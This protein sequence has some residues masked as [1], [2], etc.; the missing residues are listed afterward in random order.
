MSVPVSVTPAAAQSAEDSEVE[1]LPLA[2]LL[3]SDGYAERAE[4]V[5]LGVDL[6]EKDLDLARYYTLMGLVHSQLGRYAQAAAAWEEALSKEGVDP[7]VRLQIAQ[8]YLQNNEPEK[9][10]QTLTEVEPELDALKATW[11]VRVRAQWVSAD[12]EGAWISLARAEE[13]FPEDLEFSR[14]RV[15]LLVDMGLYH[16]ALEQGRQVLAKGGAAEDWLSLGEAL[17]GAGE[18]GDAV[19]LLEEGRLRYPLNVSLSTALARVYL[20]SGRPLAAGEVLAIAG[21]QD[22]ELLLTAAECFRQ[23]GELDRAL[24]L[25][26]RVADPQEK[27]KQRLGLYI[28]QQDW[29]R[30]VALGGRLERLSL[31]EDDAVAYALAYAWFRMGDTDR[32]TSFLTD[33]EDPRWFRDATT[34]REAIQKC[35]QDGWGCL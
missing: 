29:S 21:E 1:P 16:Q 24:Y 6:E 15:M 28:E 5:L 22:G 27:A 4:Q 11:L 18:L 25:N 8:A 35:Q 20:E 26:G 10:V 3:L 7:I 34:L 14:Q 17:R 19:L 2:S 23:A 32:A 31:T 13:R 30:A 9:A 33:I 12:H